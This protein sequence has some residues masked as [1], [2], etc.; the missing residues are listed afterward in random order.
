MDVSSK[1]NNK[2]TPEYFVNNY[3]EIIKNHIDSGLSYPESVEY[4]FPY[5]EEKNP[6]GNVIR[7]Y[8]VFRG[9]Y[10]IEIMFYRKEDDEDYLSVLLT[11]EHEKHESRL[12]SAEI[13]VSSRIFPMFPI[14]GTIPASVKMVVGS[15]KKEY[16]VS[17]SI[18][19][20]KEGDPAY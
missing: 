1:E 11:L 19:E 2:V 6:V 15:H 4:V 16:A 18:L 9:N 14:K 10:I 7:C 20:I 17:R 12:Y 13:K 8:S 3:L 5:A